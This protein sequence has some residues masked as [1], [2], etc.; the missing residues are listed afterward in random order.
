VLD[1]VRRS[2]ID[3]IWISPHDLRLS[4]D[5]WPS[6]AGCLPGHLQEFRPS[7]EV[8]FTH[9]RLTFHALAAGAA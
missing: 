9:R 3:V 6:K 5:L 2:L 7:V 4:T 1:A 8:V